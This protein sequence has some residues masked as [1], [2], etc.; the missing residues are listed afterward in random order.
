VTESRKSVHDSVLTSRSFSHPGRRKSG[1]LGPNPEMWAALRHG[2]GLNEVLQDFYTQVYAD[3]RL[4]PFF[5]GVAIEWAVQKQ[6]AFM[7]SLFTG[8]ATYMGDR[9]RNAHHWMVISDELFDHREALME[10]ALRRYGLSEELILTWRAI[11]E[12]YRKQIVKDSPRPRRVGGVEVATPG[13]VV[14]TVDVASVCDGCYAEL[15]VGEEAV[16]DTRR[17]HMRCAACAGSETSL[18]GTTAR[19]R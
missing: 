18:A 14:V 3:D 2:P 15:A 12:V 9:P 11:D 1:L 17:G 7:R 13:A 19:G 10:A 5:A 8:E 16:F 6:Y 4:S